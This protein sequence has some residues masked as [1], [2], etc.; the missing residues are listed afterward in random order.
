MPRGKLDLVLVGAKGLEDLD[1]FGSM[2]PYVI[3]TCRTQEKK[4]GVA[5]GQGSTP[6]WNENFVFNVSDGVTE[7]KVRIMD[8]DTG[9]ADDLVGEAT[10]P[11]EPVFMEGSLPTTSYTVVKDEEFRGEVRLSL[12]FSPQCERGSYEQQEEENFGGWKDSSY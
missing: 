12:T 1:V 4:S 8:S 5:S 2:D 10:I 7:L 9:T 6:E 11:L 3:I